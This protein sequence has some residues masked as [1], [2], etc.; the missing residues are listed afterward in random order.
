MDFVE[1]GVFCGRGG[2]CGGDFHCACFQ[3]EWRWGMSDLALSQAAKAM[4]GGIGDSLVPGSFALL[5]LF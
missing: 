2:L 3:G 1:A 5:F 4:P